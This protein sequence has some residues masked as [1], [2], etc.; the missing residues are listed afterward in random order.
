M[1]YIWIAEGLIGLFGLFNIRKRA[2]KVHNKE[3]SL[4][5]FLPYLM[6]FGLSILMAANR[7][8][9]DAVSFTRFFNNIKTT[10]LS[11]NDQTYYALF[12][13]IKYAIS[14]FPSL[15]YPMFHGST[16]LALWIFILLPVIKNRC[17]KPIAFFSLY[18]ISAVF[19]SDGMQFKNF[20]SVTFLILAIDCLLK[21]NLSTVKC[22]LLYYVF[23]SI[24]II[25]HFSFFTYIFIP[26]ILSK[27]FEKA[28]I[29]FPSIGFTIYVLFLF[30][31][32]TFTQLIISYVSRFYV[33][34][35]LSKYET[36]VTGVKS[37]VPVFIYMCILFMLHYFSQGEHHTRTDARSL[38]NYTLTIWRFMGLLLPLLC[39]INAVYRLY[40]NLYIWIFIIAINCIFDS[41]IRK[42]RR[43]IYSVMAMA[44]ALIIFIYLFLLRQHGEIYSPVISGKLWWGA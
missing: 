8:G 1:I 30:T 33:F 20:I 21:E 42:K 41:K 29:F 11:S 35:K 5:V 27:R 32:N 19:A 12:L 13:V 15:T 31:G 4:D 39:L 2:I 37:L 23:L 24:A 6:I 7:E 36:Q 14:I 22:I 3:L 43:Y 25:F 16:V 18:I 40:R 17:I 44:V 10:G 26:L 9:F 38:T 28:S 34:S